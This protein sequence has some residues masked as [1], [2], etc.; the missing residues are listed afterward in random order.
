MKKQ[1]NNLVI[2]AFDSNYKAALNKSWDKGAY[3]SILS[4]LR[5]SNRKKYLQNLQSRA[6]RGAYALWVYL[7]DY[8]K[9]HQEIPPV[10]IVVKGSKCDID[11]IDREYGPVEIKFGANEFTT[12]NKK[13]GYIKQQTGIKYA[14]VVLAEKSSV[15]GHER[16]YY[17][18]DG[19][20]YPLWFLTDIEKLDLNRVFYLQHAGYTQV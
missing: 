12:G 19:K 6:L 13:M 11:V 8:Y 9:R 15:P 18:R 4:Y 1:I 20:K 3:G 16:H 10:N 14:Y 7:N 17:K 5:R 2:E